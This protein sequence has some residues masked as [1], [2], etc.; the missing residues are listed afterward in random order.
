MLLSKYTL[1]QKKKSILQLTGLI[2]YFNCSRNK[3]LPGERRNVNI[4][5]AFDESAFILK[6]AY[7]SVV[8]FLLGK[9]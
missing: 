1:N 8:L 3:N 7:A 6:Q 2:V 5:M 9:K 4:Q